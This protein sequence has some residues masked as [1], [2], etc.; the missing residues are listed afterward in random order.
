[1]NTRVISR[2]LGGRR[3]ETVLL[4]IALGS[5]LAA[6][7]GGGASGGIS[8]QVVGPNGSNLNGAVVAAF[9]CNNNCQSQNDL[10]QTIGGRTTITASTSSAN[11]QIA[12]V[13]PGKYIVLAVQDTTG[14]GQ[15]GAGDLVGTTSS[16][17]TPP[18]SNANIQLQLATNAVIDGSSIAA[19]GFSS[20]R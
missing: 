14:D 5:S 1:V 11:Y 10:T 15:I 4:A 13:P 18:A 6:C 19:L 12:N 20:S 7:G 16:V 9:L 2:Q 17:V 8:G 3:L